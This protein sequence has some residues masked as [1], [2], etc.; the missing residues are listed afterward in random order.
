MVKNRRL[1][2]LLCLHC[3]KC[4]YF[5]KHERH[6]MSRSH[7]NLE[8]LLFLQRDKRRSCLHFSYFLFLSHPHLITY[9]SL[10]FTPPLLL[11][12]PPL[13]QQW[14]PVQL[15]ISSLD[16]AIPETSTP[17]LDTTVKE[18]PATVESTYHVFPQTVDINKQLWRQDANTVDLLPPYLSFYQLDSCSLIISPMWWPWTK[19]GPHPQCTKDG[20]TCRVREKKKPNRRQLCP[21]GHIWPC[22]TKAHKLM[23]FLSFLADIQDVVFSYTKGAVSVR[24]EDQDTAFDKRTRSNPGRHRLDIFFYA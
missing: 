5:H 24:R 15:T 8:W 10:T 11:L 16:L 2:N 12:I 20:W 9:T 1:H 13:L 23:T 4:K 14:H 22:A 18:T 6:L 17:P 3:S 21:I 19:S 7:G